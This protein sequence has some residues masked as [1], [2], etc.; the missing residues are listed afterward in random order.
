MDAS[1][2]RLGIGK[3]SVVRAVQATNAAERKWWWNIR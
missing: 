3:G 2:A 1:A